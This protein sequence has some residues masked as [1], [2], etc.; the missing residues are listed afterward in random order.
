MIERNEKGRQIRRYFLEME[1][2]AQTQSVQ[3]KLPAPKQKAIPP[4]EDSPEV[5]AAIETRAMAMSLRH[6]EHNKA[7]L[8]EAVKKFG[9][10]K[11]NEDLLHLIQTIELPDSK[12]VIV[13]RNTLWRLTARLATALDA[14]HTLEQETGMSWY[15]RDDDAPAPRLGATATDQ[16]RQSVLEAV[17]RFG[18]EGLKEAYLQNYC[19]PFKKLPKDKRDE[20]VNQLIDDGDLV[21]VSVKMPS[22]QIAKRLVF[23]KFVKGGSMSEMALT[24]QGG[25]HIYLLA[26][27]NRL[28]LKG[29]FKCVRQ[30]LDALLNAFEAIKTF[31]IKWLLQGLGVRQ[32]FTS[33]R[34][35]IEK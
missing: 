16:N 21:R 27:F 30:A 26:V 4:A 22:G 20:L 1:R 15:G 11:V 28:I 31:K 13:H 2:V 17:M 33:F 32:E 19:R 23:G 35:I 29:F 18:Q 7:Q 9:Q 10:G 24:L 8:R 12:L 6:Y 34:D 5:V 25:K 3:G 14:V